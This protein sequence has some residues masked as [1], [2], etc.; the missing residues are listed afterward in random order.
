MFGHQ[1]CRMG[2]VFV[3]EVGGVVW[4]REGV[5]RHGVGVDVGWAKDSVTLHFFELFRQDVGDV[6][7]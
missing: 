3:V 2:D 1:I 5:N 4:V 7:C 6:V